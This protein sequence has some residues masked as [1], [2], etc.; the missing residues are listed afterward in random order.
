MFYEV[1]GEKVDGDTSKYNSSDSDSDSSN[2]SASKA[3]GETLSDIAS[4]KSK[5]KTPKST[6]N[7]ISS[8]KIDI[9]EFEELLSTALKDGQK[10]NEKQQMKKYNTAINLWDKGIQPLGILNHRF[11]H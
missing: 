10:D 5:I 6:A 4:P 11:H 1:T 9:G 7:A 8:A 3:S 2:S